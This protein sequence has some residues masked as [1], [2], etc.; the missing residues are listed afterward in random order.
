HNLAV[1]VSRFPG[2]GDPGLVVVIHDVTELRQLERMRQDF[3]ANVSHELKTPLAIIQSTVEALQDG[4]AEDPETRDPFL[5]QVSHEAERLN[6]LIKD[7]LS[8]ARIESGSLGLEC[9]A[10]PLDKAIADCMERHQTRAE[11]KTLTL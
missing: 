2:H 11:A 1:Y 8:L 6:E 3:A 10:V 9:Q 5:A 4:A 7:L